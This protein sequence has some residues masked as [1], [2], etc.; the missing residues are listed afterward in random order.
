MQTYR[1]GTGTGGR[2]TPHGSFYLTEL[3]RPIN[4]GYGPF[5][6][7]LSGFSNVL[8]SFGS[9]PGQIGLPGTDDASRI[10][11]AASHGCI[12]MSNTDITALAKLLPLA[13][14]ITV[15]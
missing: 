5:A 3:L 13:T 1:V 2:P 10:G 7:G 12:R 8:T 14:P 15:E 9:G 4:A 11:R 6:F